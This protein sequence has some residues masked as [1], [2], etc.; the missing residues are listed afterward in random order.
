[1]AQ[2]SPMGRLGT[3]QDAADVVASSPVKTHAGFRAN[4]FLQMVQH[5][6]KSVSG[7]RSRLISSRSLQSG[8]LNANLTLS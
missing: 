8:S 3:P 7:L 1:M 4:I 6:S 5:L 2:A